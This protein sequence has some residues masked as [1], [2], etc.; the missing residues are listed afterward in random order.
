MK[1]RYDTLASIPR[2]KTRNDELKER[3]L[4]ESLLLL[5]AEGPTGITARSV[6]TV[7]GTSTAA[8]Y[9][10]FGNKSGLVRSI[11]YEGFSQLADHLDE[12]PATDEPQADLVA[13]LD[14]TR[15]FALQYPMLFD[16]MFARPFVEFEPEPD[17]HEAAKRIYSRMVRAVAALLG[18]DRTDQVTID[19]AHVVVALDRGLIG[20]ELSG[21]LGSSDE[22]IVR[23]RTMALKAAISGLRASVAR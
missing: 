7:A 13:L 8:V 10:L 14:A 17:D 5:H 15:S 18:T 11:F 6:A 3:L 21:L 12:V 22:N 23:R 1:Q 19:A 4:A 9:E 20:A 2:P 16:V